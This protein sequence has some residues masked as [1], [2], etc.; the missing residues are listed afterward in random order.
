MYIKTIDG[1]EWKLWSD[2]IDEETMHVIPK[3]KEHEFDVEF[4][5]CDM[6]TYK[7]VESFKENHFNE[8]KQFNGSLGW[9]HL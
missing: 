5:T 4:D 8:W 9:K 2:N 7:D 3:D 1:K 6:I